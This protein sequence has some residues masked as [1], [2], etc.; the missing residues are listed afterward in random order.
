MI[1]RMASYTRAHTL[2]L[3]GGSG[4]EPGQYNQKKHIALFNRFSG[5]ALHA[6]QE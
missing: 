3:S 5:L 2:S 4:S 6:A 1:T